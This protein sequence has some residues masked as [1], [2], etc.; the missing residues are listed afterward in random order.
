MPS[1]RAPKLSTRK[2]SAAALVGVA[3]GSVLLMQGNAH[4]ET[5]AQ[6]KADYN[7]KLHQSEAATEKYDGAT[8]QAA[9]LQQKVNTL[10]SQITTATNE[11]GSLERTMGLQ[12]AQQYQSAGM[13]QSLQLALESS[14]ESYLNKALASNE[15][16]Q[17]EAEL[18]KTLAADK[19][20]IAADQKLATNA[21][22][23]QQAAVA[24]AQKQ[25]A[26]ALSAAA[27]AKSLLNSLTAAQQASITKSESGPTS[28]SSVSITAVA[29]NSRAAAAVAYAKSKLGDVY[30]WG[31]TGPNTFDCSG[32]TGAAWAYAGVTIPRIAADQYSGLTHVSRAD[33]EP[34]D[35]VFYDYGE[36]ITHVAIY[37]GNNEVI[38][39]PHTGTVVQYGEI[40]TVGPVAG[41]ARP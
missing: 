19:A 40:D 25:K 36:G 15:I 10:Q 38:H 32:L 37:I 1:H 9:T 12:A 33:I 20:Q 14:P 21:L 27:S 31:A 30:V 11:M 23:Q 17:K 26:A 24:T 28:S 8:A 29:S 39:A 3:A 13:S 35:L 6:A 41:I 7:N 4:A 34:G 18:L 2:T 22:A 5:L 16:S